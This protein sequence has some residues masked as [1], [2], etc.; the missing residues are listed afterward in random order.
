MGRGR[1]RGGGGGG[2][3][4]GCSGMPWVRWTGGWWRGVRSQGGGS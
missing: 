1:N 3:G 4:E 2:G